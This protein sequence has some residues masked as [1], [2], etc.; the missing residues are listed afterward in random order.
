MHTLKVLQYDDMR[1][2]D[3]LGQ[4]QRRSAGTI[5]S[6]AKMLREIAM[7][8]RNTRYQAL[9]LP[10]PSESSE[11]LFGGYAYPTNSLL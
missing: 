8:L 1:T 7:S 2:A 10:S 9:S 3:S 11:Y 4:L 6:C 5:K